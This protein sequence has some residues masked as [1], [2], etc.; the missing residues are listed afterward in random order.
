MR[1]ALLIGAMLLFCELGVAEQSNYES[2]SDSSSAQARRVIP[3]SREDKILKEKRRRRAV[4]RTHPTT[5]KGRKEEGDQDDLITNAKMRAEAGSKS[6]FSISSALAYNGGTIEKPF[7]AKRPNIKGAAAT[8]T[9]TNLAGTISGKWNISKVDSL[10][11]GLGLRMLAPFESSVPNNAGQRY[12]AS[13][14]NLTYQ[15]LAKIYGVQAVFQFGGTMYTAKE[16]RADG[17]LG[18]LAFSPTLAY[19]FG[20]SAFT[21]G[22]SLY[23]AYRFFDKETS[24]VISSEKDEDGSMIYYLAGSSQDDYSLAYYP[25]M[26]Y[27]LNSIFNLRTLVGFG[28]DHARVEDNAFAYK[29]NKVYQSV[30]IGISITR[31]IFLYPNIQFLPDNIRS[32]LTNVALSA[33]VNLF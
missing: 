23:G 25:F 1:F 19:D 33:S 24:E 32:D 7:A 6:K 5:T 27:Q 26:E 12:Q 20:G 4:E 29:K 9:Y 14:P 16:V 10:F 15:R 17:S 21:I 3:G 31:D 30:G 8:P 2:S 11:L 28:Y 22:V 13:E 18:E